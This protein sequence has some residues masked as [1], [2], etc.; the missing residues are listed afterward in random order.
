M[1]SGTGWGS[2]VVRHLIRMPMGQ[3][4]LDGWGLVWRVRWGHPVRV[5]YKGGNPGCCRVRRMMLG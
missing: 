4:G 5:G 3:V 2:G 1:G